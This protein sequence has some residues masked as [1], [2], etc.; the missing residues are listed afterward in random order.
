MF[1]KFL[2]SN[3]LLLFT[4]IS[5]SLSANLDH[6]FKKPEDKT[7]GHSIKNID[8]IYMINLDE[9]KEKLRLYVCAGCRHFK[10]DI[11]EQCG[12][13]IKLKAMLYAETCPINKW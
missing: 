5:I 4:L 2:K 7:T 6:F 1:F 12:C 11:C 8:F 9:E 13:F 10:C 3:L